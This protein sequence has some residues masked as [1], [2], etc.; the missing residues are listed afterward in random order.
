MKKEDWGKVNERKEQEMSS[1]QPKADAKEPFF[2][3]ENHILKK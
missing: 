2:F 1:S 3:R